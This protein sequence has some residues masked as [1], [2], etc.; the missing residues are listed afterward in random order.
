MRPDLGHPLAGQAAFCDETSQEVGEFEASKARCVES[1][2]VLEPVSKLAGD[3]PSTLIPAHKTCEHRGVDDNRHSSDLASGGQVFASLKDE[4]DR[5]H[6][7]QV[8]AKLRQLLQSRQ[9]IWVRDLR[10]HD[11]LLGKERHDDLG[12]FD[13]GA[14]SLSSTWPFVKTPSTLL[15]MIVLLSSTIVAR[16]HGQIEGRYGILSASV[17]SAPPATFSRYASGERLRNAGSGK[18]STSY[19]VA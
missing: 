10:R 3:A 6:S 18:S 9:R 5:I 11:G 12:P 15:S 4:L 13:G 2:T 7:R 19:R 8:T 14:S 16:G 17:F 1:L